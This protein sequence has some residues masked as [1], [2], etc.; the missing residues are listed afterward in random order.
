MEAAT[1][2]RWDLRGKVVQYIGH[3]QYD[4]MVATSRRITMRN[5]AHLRK[6]KFDVDVMEEIVT[7]PPATRPDP[8]KME[9]LEERKET[10]GPTI[11]ECE[12]NLLG[13]AK[14]PQ[15]SPAKGLAPTL[16]GGQGQGWSF[17]VV[18]NEAIIQNNYIGN[19]L[20]DMQ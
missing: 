18:I 15:T 19:G 2:T 3:N 4:V 9:R 1:P 10:G 16:G 13:P 12:E 14:T 11:Q 17:L 8:E 6:L 20:W 5:Q 7:P